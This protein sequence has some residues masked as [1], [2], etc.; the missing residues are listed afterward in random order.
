[1]EVGR[2]VCSPVRRRNAP[3][4]C[5]IN[6]SPSKAGEELRPDFCAERLKALADPTRLRLVTALQVGELAVTDLAELLELEMVTVSHHLQILKHANLIVP[7]REGRFIYYRLHEDLFRRTGNG[8][9]FL[10]LG[11]CRLEIAKSK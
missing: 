4:E 7:R 8:A 1:M 2:V 5:I 6:A 3:K 10:D 9:G 11:C